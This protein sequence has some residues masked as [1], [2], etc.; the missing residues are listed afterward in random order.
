[1]YKELQ[2]NPL[3]KALQYNPDAIKLAQEKGL[4]DSFSSSS[5]FASFLDYTDHDNNDYDD[6]N[7]NNNNSDKRRQKK[8]PLG[9]KWQEDF[10]ACAI[11]ALFQ[12]SKTLTNYY[13][14]IHQEEYNRRGINDKTRRTLVVEDPKDNKD[15]STTTTTMPLP[16]EDQ[17]SK[18][19]RFK[20]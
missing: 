5:S 13:C 8:R 9:W 11:R 6:N 4:L 15:I 19:N 7:H 12:A 20:Y 10:K 1:M 3:H 2:C 14:K 17:K 16:G 18:A